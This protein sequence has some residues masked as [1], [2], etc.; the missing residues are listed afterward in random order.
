[1]ARDDW[2]IRIELPEETHAHGLLG[3]LAAVGGGDDAR[4]LE[5]ELEGRR[6]AVSRDGSTVFV[7]TASSLEAESARRAVQTELDGLGARATLVRLEHWL[8]DEERWDDEPRDETWEQDELDRGYAPWE[9]R[10]EK[11]S[12]AEAVELA[13]RLEAEGLPVVQRFSYV[14]VGAASEPE[15]RELAKRIGGEVE[16]GGELVY[17]TAPGNPFAVFGGLGGDAIPL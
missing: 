16:G 10:V 13:E 9:V 4:R 5:Q 3:R 11:G 2:R 17:E 1:M 8:A 14:F 15:A 12:R 6:L 7:Y